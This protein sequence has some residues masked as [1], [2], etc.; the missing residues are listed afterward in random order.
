MIGRVANRRGQLQCGLGGDQVA[1]G[2][3]LGRTDLQDQMA[4]GLQMGRGLRDDPGDDRQAVGPAVESEV[5]LVVADAGL[6]GGDVLV[7]GCT[8]DSTR[9]ASKGGS[10]AT[11]S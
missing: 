7:W 2:A 4:A 8:A 3:L 10:S 1:D 6:Q 5:G 11:G 9:I